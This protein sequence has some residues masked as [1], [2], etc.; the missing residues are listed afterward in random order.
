[1]R[2]SLMPLIHLCRRLAKPAPCPGSACWRSACF[3]YWIACG[4][5]GAL[6]RRES[7]FE[8][9]CRALGSIGEIGVPVKAASGQR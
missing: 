9:V 1:M 8:R 6:E 4:T 5:G 3:F 2:R 7:K